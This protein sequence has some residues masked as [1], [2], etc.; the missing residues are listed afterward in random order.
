MENEKHERII[1]IQKH[2]SFLVEEFEYRLQEAA[3]KM[4]IETSL[5]PEDLDNPG[6]LAPEDYNEESALEWDV[7]TSDWRFITR[8]L[9]STTN[10]L[11]A[12]ALDLNRD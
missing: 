1:E 2:T 6:E 11:V 7:A 9:L 5:D 3:Y 10:E 8:Q 12:E 4:M